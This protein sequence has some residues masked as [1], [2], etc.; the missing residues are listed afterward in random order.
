MH[1]HP[2]Q[3]PHAVAQRSQVHHPVA[4]AAHIQLY[5]DLVGQWANAE[6]VGAEK[7]TA[8]IQVH[9]VRLGAAELPAEDE[10]R[11]SV[12]DLVTI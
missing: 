11:H 5:A 2:L 9:S 3:S 4:Q 10:V 1:Q 12:S 7:H 6:H 8:Q